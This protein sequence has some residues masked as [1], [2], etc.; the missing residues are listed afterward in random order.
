MRLPQVA[1][2]VVLAIAAV[3]IAYYYPQLP[4]VMASHFDISGAPN[5]W[6]PKS[7]FFGLFCFIYIFY[8]AL[9][10]ALPHLL[11]VSPPS[12]INMPNKSYWLAPARRE[13][14]A[15]LLGDHMA[16][17]GIALTVFLIA[18][19]QLVIVANLPGHSGNLGP[20]V[21]WLLGI[22]LTFT[23]VWLIRLVRSFRLPSGVI[24]R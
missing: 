11:M 13:I 15:H 19:C 5:S 23:L 16:W 4:S 6:M 12:L 10:W 9:F 2:V 20:W 14:T 3:Q 8:A 24:T 18:G 22:Y 21:W 1:L 7:A 17:F